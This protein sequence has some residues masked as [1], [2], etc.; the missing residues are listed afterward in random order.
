[1][2]KSTG[3]AL[4]EAAQ[5]MIQQNATLSASANPQ[6]PKPVEVVLTPEQHAARRRRQIMDGY[7]ALHEK[8]KR[9]SEARI[10]RS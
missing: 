1:M 9:E 10:V 7:I 2:R 6:A 4:F 8:Y 3:H 5:M